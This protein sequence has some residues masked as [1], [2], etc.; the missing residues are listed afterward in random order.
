MRKIAFVL[1]V[2]LVLG[3]VASASSEVARTRP[4]EMDTKLQEWCMGYFREGD[5]TEHFRSR[6]AQDLAELEMKEMTI[7]PDLVTMTEIE[8]N[9]PTEIRNYGDIWVWPSTNEASPYAVFV[10]RL[11]PTEM[12]IA[13]VK[14]REAH[15]LRLDARDVRRHFKWTGTHFLEE[16]PNPTGS[17]ELV[18]YVSPFGDALILIEKPSSPDSIQNVPLPHITASG[19]IC[20]I[21]VMDTWKPK[22]EKEPT[23]S[24][25][26]D[27][28]LLNS[29]LSYVLGEHPEPASRRHPKE[30]APLD[31]KDAVFPPD[32]V[33]KTE[34][35]GDVPPAIRKYQ[36]RW[37]LRLINKSYIPYAAFVERLTPT[38]MTIALVVK[39]EAGHKLDPAK[40]FR[41]RLDWTG[42]AFIGR[43]V[44][45]WGGIDLSVGVSPFG[46]AMILAASNDREGHLLGCLFS[47]QP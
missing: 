20:F 18:A 14:T 15:P 2:L 5:R 24:E 29:C 37:A 16:T 36:G 43:N 30:T 17:P 42:D 45:M 19:G 12:T 3:S 7:P 21:S 44:D 25:I 31:L 33:T 32:L 34:I 26:S 6:P 23:P 9:P 28:K 39:P 38:E 1:C 40:G 8:G 11:T 13:I 35:I 46:D 10:E 47:E 41:H 27:N 22:R 4:S